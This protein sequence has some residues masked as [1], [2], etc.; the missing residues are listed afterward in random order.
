MTT[1]ALLIPT[2]AINM[3]RAQTLKDLSH[4]LA[5]TDIV[6]LELIAQV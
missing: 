1:S 2:I 5:I 4:V 6:V 3:Q